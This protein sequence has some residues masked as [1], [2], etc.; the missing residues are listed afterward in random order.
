MPKVTVVGAGVFKLT[1]AL[2]LPRHYDVTIVACD[3]PGDLDSLDW[4]SPWAGAGFGGGGTKPND[5]EELEMLQAA[6]RYYWTC[7]G[8]TQSRA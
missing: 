1:I 6:F 8:A 7:P 3:M 5:A 2:S 4:A